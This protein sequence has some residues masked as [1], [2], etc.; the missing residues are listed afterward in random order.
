[1]KLIMSEWPPSRQFGKRIKEHIPKSI[2]EFCTSNEKSKSIR[3]VNATKRSA[4]AQHL[5]NNLNCASNYNLKRFKTIK[6]CFH[7]FDLIKLEATCI[8]LRK[9]KLCKHKDFDYAVLLFS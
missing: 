7:I 6:N 4:I 1:M 8:L 3:V 9:P 2:D 5:V